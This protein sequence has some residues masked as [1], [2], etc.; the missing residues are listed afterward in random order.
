MDAFVKSYATY[1]TIKKASVITS[2][3]TLDSLDAVSSSVTIV[4]TEIGPA[5]IRDWIIIDGMRCTSITA[6]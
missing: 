2:S 5:N 3:L 4:G 6:V 1:R